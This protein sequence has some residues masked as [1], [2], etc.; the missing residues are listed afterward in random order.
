MRGGE[1]SL[2]GVDEEKLGGV[3]VAGSEASWVWMYGGSF[4]RWKTLDTEPE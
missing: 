3:D 1:G 2:R 4:S